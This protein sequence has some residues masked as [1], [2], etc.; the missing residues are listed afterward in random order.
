MGLVSAFVLIP[1][2]L[3]NGLFVLFW[4][5]MGQGE[6]DIFCHLRAGFLLVELMSIHS[7]ERS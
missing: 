1:L 3:Q 7:R 2:Q 5:I 6:N 4:N